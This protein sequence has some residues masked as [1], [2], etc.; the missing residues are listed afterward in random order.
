VSMKARQKNEDNYGRI[1][2]S[3]SFAAS[4]LIRG[5]H[6]HNRKEELEIVC[7]VDKKYIKKNIQEGDSKTV[8]NSLTMRKDINVIQSYYL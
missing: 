3:V 1:S 7:L 2:P 5:R 8:T 6:F 4:S